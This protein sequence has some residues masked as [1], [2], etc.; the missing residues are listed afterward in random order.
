MLCHC[1]PLFGIKTGQPNQVTEEN[2]WKE[3]YGAWHAIIASKIEL[4]FKEWFADFQL[5]YKQHQNCLKP[6]QYIKDMWLD[7]HKERIMK[8]W[9]DQH[10][11]FGNIAT[12]R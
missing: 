12:S 6:L 10:L 8:A 3:F 11:Y 2:L 1:Q 4:M 9:V 5:K 7:V